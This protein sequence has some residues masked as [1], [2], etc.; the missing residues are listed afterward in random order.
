MILGAAIQFESSATIQFGLLLLIG[1]PVAR[2]LLS[3]IGFLRERDFTYV[4]FT[5]V[6]LAVL[7]SSLFFGQVS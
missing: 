6:V 3:V 4:G 7:L 2:V 1:T 5:L